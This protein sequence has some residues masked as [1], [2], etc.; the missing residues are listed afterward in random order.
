MNKIPKTLQFS[1]SKKPKSCSICVSTNDQMSH[2]LADLLPWNSH[3]IWIRSVWAELP[4]YEST[5]MA[6]AANERLAENL[7]LGGLFKQKAHCSGGG[8]KKQS[9][10]KISVWL[11]EA[12]NCFVS[13][14]GKKE[15]IWSFGKEKTVVMQ[16]SLK[17]CSMS[18]R[19][20]TGS[21]CWYPS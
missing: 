2:R 6:K 4:H 17:S 10:L 20:E 21:S 18:R 15:R 16:N 13:K 3:I 14:W 8:Q 9:L 5:L 12:E 7:T 11:F 1:N 19:S